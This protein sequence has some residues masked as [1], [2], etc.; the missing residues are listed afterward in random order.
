MATCLKEISLISFDKSVKPR[1]YNDIN[2]LLPRSPCTNVQF[3]ALNHHREHCVGGWICQHYYILSKYIIPTGGNDNRMCPGFSISR[4]GRWIKT[5]E[6][7]FWWKW[8]VWQR[9]EELDFGLEMNELAQLTWLE[10]S[11]FPIAWTERERKKVLY[12]HANMYNL[13]KKFDT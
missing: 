3:V 12:R 5:S 13:R 8:S 9:W 7:K 11:K 10:K 6:Q 4:T 2:P 1:G